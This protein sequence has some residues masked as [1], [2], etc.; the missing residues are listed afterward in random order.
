MEEN[1]KM[2]SMIMKGITIL[3]I[4]G[5]PIILYNETPE[6]RKRLLNSWTTSILISVAVC[7]A[8]RR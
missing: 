5:I 6:E 2:I 4:I 1:L 3:L 7:S 8:L